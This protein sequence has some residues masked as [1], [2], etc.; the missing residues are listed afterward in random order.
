LKQ[1]HDL[2]AAVLAHGVEDVDRTGVG[3]LSIFGTQHRYDLSDGKIPVVTTKKLFWR[4]VVEELLWMM[5]GETNCKT[6]Q[7][8]RVRIWDAWAS[9][10]GELGP[11]YGAQWRKWQGVCNEDIYIIDQ[12]GDVVKRIKAMP[13]SRRHIVSAWNVAEIPN[14]ALPPCHMMFQFYVR[15][16][17]ISCQMY[18]RSADLF[19]GV[20]FNIASYALL[21]KMVAQLTGNKPKEFVH[22]IGDAHIY[23]NHIDQV[24]E[25]LRRAPTGTPTVEFSNKALECKTVDDFG[26]TDY[27]DYRLMNYAPHPSISAPIAK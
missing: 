18:Q 17:E 5:R 13:T 15:N 16:G 4:G 11:I 7:E 14:M 21:T 3:T 2:L 6:L 19:L 24:T 10:S 25:L 20:P 1:Y 22:T 26:K 8:K 27:T 12:L 9:P 23:K